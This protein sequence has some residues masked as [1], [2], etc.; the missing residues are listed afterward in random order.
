MSQNEQIKRID[1]GH[2][3]TGFLLVATIAA[4]AI[5]GT[6]GLTPDVTHPMDKVAHFLG[7]ALF[8]FLFGRFFNAYVVATVMVFLCGGALECLQYFI[9]G[10]TFSYADIAANCGGALFVLFLRWML[11]GAGLSLAYFKPVSAKPALVPHY[12]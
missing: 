7:F 2:T 5:M 4:G 6:T 9:P 12:S 8:T 11:D 3:L 10:R 1:A